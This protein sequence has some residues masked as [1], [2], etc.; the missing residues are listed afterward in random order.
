LLYVVPKGEG[1]YSSY[2]FSGTK[3][4]LSF[5]SDTL[6]VKYAWPKYAQDAMFDFGG[7][8][9]NVSATTLQEGSLTEARDG[10]RTADSLTSHELAHQWFGDFVTCKD[11]GDTWL[12]ESFATFMQMAY[13]EHSRGENAYYEEVDNNTRGY[14]AES[15]RFER[16]ISTKLY[17]NPNDM[18]GQGTTY[19]K[20]G[21]VLHTLRRFLGDQSFWAGLNLYLKTN[22][23]TPVQASQ[24]CRA[25]TEA[26]G[27]NCEPFFDQWIFKPGHPT[28]EFTWSYDESSKMV[29]VHL[30]QVQDTS[31]GTPIY[32]I[33]AKMLFIVDGSLNRAAFQLNEADQVLSFG[34]F[35]KK[36]DA[37]LLDPDHDFL[38]EIRNVHW[39]PD[40]Q[41]AIMQFAPVGVDRMLAMR[42]LLSDKPS[43]ED[44]RLAVKV[45]SADRDAFPAFRSI[46]PLSALERPDLRPFFESQ[47][48]HASFL[49]RIEAVSALSLL[50]A[51]PGTTS[52][53][54]ALIN[55]KSPI[56]VVTGCIRALAAWDAK[57]NADVFKKALTI[58][59]RYDRIKH[60]AEYA[61]GN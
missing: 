55:D 43:D 32:R 28:L 11:W 41:R 9:E 59:S 23:H 54:R 5:Y 21:V 35:T 6:G 48:D 57:G 7:G 44:V 49:R 17:S 51:D 13:F 1:I 27:I 36:P 31:H 19:G 50:P 4:M 33:P 61:L 12:N 10:F 20:G 40:E 53:L 34:P 16:P 46:A 29:Q 14:L 15:R 38:R 26:S 39:T 52:K 8:M 58:P 42:E 18:F 45:M 37:A 3:D 24:L 30:R 60:A 22:A 47:L 25:F 56:Y 2:T